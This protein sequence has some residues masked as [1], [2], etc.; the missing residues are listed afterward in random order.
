MSG[1]TDRQTDTHTQNS[2]NINSSSSKNNNKNI[3]KQQQQTITTTTT[4]TTQRDI[5]EELILFQHR[6]HDPKNSCCVF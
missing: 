6:L 5:S 4:T 2:K 1:V 3:I